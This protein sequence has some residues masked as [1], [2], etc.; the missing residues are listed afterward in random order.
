M[1][2]EISS[3]SQNPPNLIRK[4]TSVIRPSNRF[5]RIPLRELWRFR[6]LLYFLVW[7]DLKVRYKQSLLGVGWII[8]QPVLTMLMF[9][10]IFN[11]ILGIETGGKAPYPVMVF[12]AL[13]PWQ[14]FA[15]SL[16]RSSTSLVGNAQLISKIYFPRMLIP[17]ANVLT[18]LVDFGIGFVVLLAMMAFYGLKPDSSFMALPLALLLALLAA[19]GVG[20]WLSALNVQYR[21]VQHLAP[22][23]VQ[24]WMYATPIIYS[25]S[26]IPENWQWL[27]NLNP[28]VCVVQIFQQ[29]LLNEAGFS[30]QN[31]ISVVIVLLILVSGVLY[32]QKVERVFA[33]IV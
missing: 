22:F 28:M 24:I 26:Q 8:L 17:I 14:Y 23:L 13:L 9:T 33:D 27:Y 31:W 15:N 2:K 12:T 30:G 16:G 10:I 5:M 18:G 25:I 32:F 19:L 7:R 6:E 20:F 4:P 29:V 21:D 1:A 3:L 11:R